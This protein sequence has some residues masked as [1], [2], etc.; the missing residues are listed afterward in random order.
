MQN[1][2][3]IM[4]ILVVK[5]SVHSLALGLWSRKK[6][7]RRLNET[8]GVQVSLPG[9]LCASNALNENLQPESV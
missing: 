5:C 4:F 7:Q 6:L 9:A 8:R 1:K 3:E 2:R